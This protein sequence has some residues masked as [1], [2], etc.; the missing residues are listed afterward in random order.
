[1]SFKF[2][3]PFLVLCQIWLI[4]KIREEESIL[5]VLNFNKVYTKTMDTV[6][7]RYLNSLHMKM[8]K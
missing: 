1:M 7:Y 4:L 8:I 6:L 3:I 2:M 5:K